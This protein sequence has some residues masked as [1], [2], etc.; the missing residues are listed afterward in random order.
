VK[1]EPLKLMPLD[2]FGKLV[3]RLARVPKETADQKRAPRMPRKKRLE[4]KTQRRLKK[5][6]VTP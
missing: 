4:P 3:G 6:K 5:E 1:K 2:E